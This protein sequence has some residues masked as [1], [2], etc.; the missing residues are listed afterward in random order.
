MMKPDT[1][2]AGRP[3]LYMP[4]EVVYHSRVML[5]HKES[6]VVGPRFETSS[7]DKRPCLSQPPKSNE[8]AGGRECALLRR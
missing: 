6:D 7:V 4:L 5:V 8:D 1:D 2:Q 3:Y